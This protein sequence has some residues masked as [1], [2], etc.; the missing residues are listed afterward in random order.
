MSEREVRERTLGEVD[1][2]VHIYIANEFGMQLESN[3]K[4]S[5]GLLP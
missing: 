2:E 5:L 3:A 4:H 1:V